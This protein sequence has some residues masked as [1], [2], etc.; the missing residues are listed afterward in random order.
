MDLLIDQFD[1]TQVLNKVFSNAHMPHESRE[2][3]L[4]NKAGHSWPVKWL[5]KTTTNSSGFS[6]G[7]RGFALDNR[8]EESDVCVFEMVD[9]KYFVILVHLFRAIGQPSEDEG[10]YRPS[11]GRGRNAN[12]RKRKAIDSPLDTRCTKIKLF[13]SGDLKSPAGCSRAKYLYHT[14]SQEAENLA[15]MVGCSQKQQKDTCTA[16]HGKVLHQDEGKEVTSTAI[17]SSCDTDF[18]SDNPSSEALE[19]FE[20]RTALQIRPLHAFQF[21][22]RKTGSFRDYLMDLGKELVGQQAALAAP[23]RS[24]PPASRKT[25]ISP[26]LEV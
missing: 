2:V 9:E 20:R 4:C 13:H 18:T 26:S 22:R 3:T 10:D 19:T 5:F 15:Q 8:L 25:Q 16:S 12:R 23:K 7:W 21:P 6:G 11:P 17:T 14:Q 1:V 24:S